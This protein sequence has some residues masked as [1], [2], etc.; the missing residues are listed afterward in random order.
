MSKTH[1]DAV[2]PEVEAANLLIDWALDHPEL[3]QTD[4]ART[5]DMLNHIRG[6]MED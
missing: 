5:M 1:D 3:F 4:L 6:L 2:A